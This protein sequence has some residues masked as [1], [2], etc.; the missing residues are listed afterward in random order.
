MIN[1]HF[2]ENINQFQLKMLMFKDLNNDQQFFIIYLII[3]FD[4]TH[5]FTVINY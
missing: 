2:D 4:K 3:A 5:A 1:K